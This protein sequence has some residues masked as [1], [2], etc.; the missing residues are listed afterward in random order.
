[1]LSGELNATMFNWSCL[2][3]DAYKHDPPCSHLHFHV[4]PRYKGLVH[5]GKIAFQDHEFSHHY[6]NHAP[7]I[8]DD[9]V[10]QNLFNMLRSK[11]GIYFTE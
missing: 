6:N 5:L 4:R 2:M 1:M 11:V 9:E 8:V 7:A 3:N 10:L